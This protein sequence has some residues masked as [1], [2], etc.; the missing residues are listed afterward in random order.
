MGG[1]SRWEYFRAI[2]RRYRGAS[3][4]ERGRIL[5]EFSR[6][7]GYNRKYAIRKLSGPPPGERPRARRR[8]KRRPLYGPQVISILRELWEAAGYPWSVRLKAMVPVWMPWIRRRYHTTPELEGRLLSISPRQ[9]DRRLESQKA[10]MRRRLYGR[11]KPGTLLKHQ[12]PLRTD[13]WDVKSPG[14]AEVDLVSH[15]GNCGEG[16]FVYSLNTTDILSGWV[17]TRATLGKGKVEVREALE[18][19]QEAFPFR[20]RGIDSD[21]GSEFINEELWGYC[22]QQKIQFTRGR[23]YKKDDNAHIEQKN[24]THVRKLLGWDRYDTQAAPDAINALYGKEWRLMMNL[25]QPSVKL[26]GKKRVGSRLLRKY[27]VATTPLDRLLSC[28]QGDAEKLQHLLLLRSRLDPFRLAETI[29]RKVQRI[30]RLANRARSPRSIRKQTSAAGPAPSQKG[31]YHLSDPLEKR[32][33]AA[34][35]AKKSSSVK[36]VEADGVWKAARGAFPHPLENASR[37]PHLPQPQPTNGRRKTKK[38]GLPFQM[39][40]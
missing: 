3:R 25:F 10:S 14:F 5:E 7:C 17:E 15:S 26:I 9:I 2:F 21:N 30:G 20:L 4:P 40:R 19:I 38:P 24:W 8:G 28:G 18:Q 31:G 36:A 13:H 6:V 37:F 12:I 11:T 22:K 33:P 27:D 35:C 32:L 23:P 34:S 16:E 1:R 39:S 29:D